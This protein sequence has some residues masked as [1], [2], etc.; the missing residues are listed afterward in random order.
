LDALEERSFAFAGNRTTIPLSR[1]TPA[2]RCTDGTIPA[3]YSS[4]TSIKFP[5]KQQL[6]DF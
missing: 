3:P 4:N 2:I 1:S 5:S 6:P